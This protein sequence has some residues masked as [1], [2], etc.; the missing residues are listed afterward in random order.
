[1]QVSGD[2]KHINITKCFPVLCYGLEAC[3]LR[4]TY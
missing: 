4:Y 3:P 2:A 1:M